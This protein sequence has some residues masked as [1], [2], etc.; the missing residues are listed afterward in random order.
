MFNVAVYTLTRDRLDYTRRSF[1]SLKAKA[2]YPYDHYIVDNGSVDGTADWLK[3]HESEFAGII[4][5]S[6]NQGISIASN[7]ALNMILFEPNK[8]QLIIKMDNDCEVESEGI[9]H[10]I[11]EMYQSLGEFS[12]KYILSPYVNGINNQPTRG[13]FDQIAG[14]RIGMTGIV[15]GLFHIVP[16]SVYAV[17]KF[18][19]TLPKAKG[20]DDHFC[21]WFKTNGGEL[22]YIEGLFVCHMDGT[23]KQAQVYP[24]YFKR[25]WEE[26]KL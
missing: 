9:I 19:D 12:P 11:V 24:E 25:K 1:D 5:N 22:G 13:R 18:P 17:Y 8:Y 15:G 26:E 10:Q 21:H 16:A 3:E 2:G 23:D 6:E 20:Q 14:R 4:Y 7:Q